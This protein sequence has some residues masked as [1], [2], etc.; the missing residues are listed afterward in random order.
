MTAYPRRKAADTEREQYIETRAARQRVLAGV[1]ARRRLLRARMRLRH[2][3]DEEEGKHD[4]P[5]HPD[6]A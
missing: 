5:D 1:E 2:L 3:Q 4:E 6:I